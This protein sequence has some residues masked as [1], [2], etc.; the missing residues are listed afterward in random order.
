MSAYCC[1]CS[2]KRGRRCHCFLY[3]CY[4]TGPVHGGHKVTYTIILWARLLNDNFQK[5]PIFYVYWLLIFFLKNFKIHKK[6]LI[7]LILKKNMWTFCPFWPWRSHS[8]LI[9]HTLNK[10]K[11]TNIFLLLPN[12]TFLPHSPSEDSDPRRP[13]HGQ[14]CT[15]APTAGEEVYRGV[16]P[17]PG[18]PGHQHTLELQK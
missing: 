9:G 15:V 12:K 16:H 17:Y 13:Q 7:Y 6:V 4:S 5:A 1:Q 18:D 8:C 3:I 2:L 14:E 10:H 11:Q